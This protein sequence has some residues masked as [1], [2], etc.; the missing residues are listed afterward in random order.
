MTETPLAVDPT[1]DGATFA[2][3]FAHASR[4]YVGPRANGTGAVSMRADGSDPAPADFAF[5]EDVTNNRHRNT[6]TPPYPSIGATGCAFDTPA[7]GPDNE[8]GRGLFAAGRFDGEDWLVVAGAR[9]AGDFDYVYLSNST[10]PTLTFR[11]V[12]LSAPLGGQTLGISAMHVFN[13]RLYLGFPDS[14]AN[15][16]YLVALLRAPAAPGL[17]AVAG[18]G[19][20]PAAQDACDLEADAIPGVGDSSS[21]VVII[22]AITDFNNRLYLANAGGVSRSLSDAP[23][24][25]TL[26]GQWVGVTPT[27][28][29]YAASPS[30]TTSKTADLEPTDKA[31]PAFAAFGGR[32][33]LS[34]NSAAGPQLWM[35]APGVVAGP[36]PASAT[37]CD[38][39][40]WTLV[41]TNTTLNPDLSQFDNT[42]HQRATLLA[43][44]ANHLYLGFDSATGVNI[45]QT[46]ATAP[47]GPA[48]FTGEGDCS[49]AAHPA[50]CPG[51]GGTGFGLATNTR[52]LA[53][54]MLRLG[55]RDYLYIVTGDGSGPVRVYRIPD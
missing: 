55:A 52:I 42:A 36:A 12:D 27:A 29:A 26:A 51:L 50:S 25:G 16:P 48:D 1:G 19:C 23:L 40:D 2:F 10:E 43:A 33:F 41:A 39:G 13:E 44:G 22:D 53:S 30:V 46:T 24:A 21:A 49:A 11:Y 6:T 31:V 45:F 8:D 20:I 15:R 4:I 47:A 38:G 14:G 32:L 34:R 18:A 35:C 9:S 3:V 17:D 28:A 5:L 7:C 37:D 54:I